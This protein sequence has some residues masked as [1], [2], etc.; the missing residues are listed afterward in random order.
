VG[1]VEV[2]SVVVAVSD[3][4]VELAVP[5]APLVVLVVA[6]SVG[7]IDGASMMTV[8]VEVAVRPDW[9]VAT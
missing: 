6:V 9:A 7:T 4:G 5:L 3:A 1:A 8:L 2:A